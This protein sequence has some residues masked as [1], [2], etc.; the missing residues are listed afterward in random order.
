MQDVKLDEAMLKSWKVEDKGAYGVL[1]GA[2]VTLAK[3]DATLELRTFQGELL[4]SQPDG[5]VLPRTLRRFVELAVAG[6]FSAMVSR[7]VDVLEADRANRPA[8]TVNQ[9]AVVERRIA[10]MFRT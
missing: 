4:W 3:D 7:F 9:R 10:G 1:V 8:G 2:V 6:G 5:S